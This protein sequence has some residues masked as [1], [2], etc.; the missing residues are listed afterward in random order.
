MLNE[1]D[2]LA[3][4]RTASM[5]FVTF[6]HLASCLRFALLWYM[7]LMAELAS[8]CCL[9]TAATDHAWPSAPLQH[10]ALPVAPGARLHAA[11]DRLRQEVRCWRRAGPAGHGRGWKVG[12]K[13]RGCGERFQGNGG[14]YSACR[15]LHSVPHRADITPMGTLVEV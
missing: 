2:K 7:L 8:L 10:Q 13:G 14:T 1:K 4:D 6:I 15:P 9:S 11:H 3:R 12:L 5:S